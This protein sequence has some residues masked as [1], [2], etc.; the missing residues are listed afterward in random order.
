MDAMQYEQ[1]GWKNDDTAFL[2]GN[3]L[4]KLG[5]ETAFAYGD[6][7]LEPRMK[8]MKLPKNSSLEAWS[9]AANKLYQPGFEA[10]GFALL[11]SFA[12]PLMR[13]I[14]GNTDGGAILALFS[15]DSGHGK[16]KALEAIASVWGQYDAL[17]TAGKD[18]A[19]AKFNIISKACHLPVYEEELAQRDPVI[20][21]DF[22]KDF[23]MGRD[24]NRSQRDGSVAFKNTRYQTIMISASN[25]S[26]F[27]IVKQSGDRGAV[28]RVFELNIDMPDGLDFKYFRSIA[29]DMLANCGHA[30][31]A[32]G[33]VLMRPGCVEWIKEALR[34]AEQDYIRKLETAPEH[35]FVVWVMATCKVM[36]QLVNA[37][38]ILSFDPARIMEWAEGKAHERF[39][40]TLHVAP[41]P[42]I[43]SRYI[44][45][46]FNADA[47]V[48]A[49][50]FHAKMPTTIIRWPDRKLTM[51]M[52][53][54][55]QRLYIAI[56]PFKEWLRAHHA[57]FGT[58]QKRLVNTR[59][60]LNK[61]RLTT[62]AAGTGTSPG[63][64]M[65]W[66]IDTAHPDLGE[67]VVAPELVKDLPPVEVLTLKK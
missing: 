34:S 63:R 33:Y 36:A 28:A 12:A 25:R 37:A 59:V 8:A 18:T 13:F 51:R 29:N 2:V 44:N 6:K 9:A 64:V 4:I 65:C 15:E 54:D 42:G 52:E 56:E 19:N 30:G 62:L 5:G 27:E 10:H 45:E 38:G 26:L 16:S 32:I 31:R 23:T 53:R 47:L 24:K 67:V 14:C 57:D 1:F 17:S 11:A 21:A 7:H 49:K 46:N 60:V 50:E 55:P 35:R 43:L 3:A 22:I 66:E 61:Q 39:S 58:L 48:V 41:P 40:D 20:A